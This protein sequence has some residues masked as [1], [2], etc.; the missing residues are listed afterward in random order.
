MYLPLIASEVQLWPVPL[1]ALKE[2]LETL[3]NL[4]SDDEKDRAS[5]FVFEKDR[6]SF[7][8]RRGALRLLLSMY[9]NLPAHEIRFLYSASGKPHF[10]LET[11]LSFNASHSGSIAVI[12][13]TRGCEVGVDVELIQEID[14]MDALAKSH[15][16]EPEW[17]ELLTIPT[18]KRSPAFYRC[19][20][21]KEAFAK[22][23]GQ[24][25]FA[26]LHQSCTL[27]PQ[28]TL[29]DFD[30]QSIYVGAVAYQS[31]SKTLTIFNSKKLFQSLEN[32][33]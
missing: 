19:W 1:A 16:S 3:S 29:Q 5:R 4:L 25:I 26:S 8:L 28:W 11:N 6:T 13:F 33:C 7:A 12:A 10:S 20:T 21:R 27:G 32:S 2:H 9:L 14:E 18:D 31:E 30:L 24:G 23:T 15:F 17:N 22:A